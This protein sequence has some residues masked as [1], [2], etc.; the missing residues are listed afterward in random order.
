MF[1]HLYLQ[2]GLRQAISPEY[3]LRCVECR[4]QETPFGQGMV[5]CG[6]TF[7]NHP[8]NRKQALVI[9]LN[10]KQYSKVKI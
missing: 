3:F 5:W 1:V 10:K 6:N 9:L 2:I 7:V 8:A 4:R